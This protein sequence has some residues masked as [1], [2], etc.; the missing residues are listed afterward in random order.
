MSK[1]KIVAAA[2]L[3]T[4]LTAGRAEAFCLFSCDPTADNARSVF[5]NRL[6]QKFDPDVKVVKFEVSRFWQLDVEG[7]GH[8]AVEFYFTGTAEFPKGANLDCKPDEA[9]AVKEGCSASK[10]YSTTVSNQEIKGRQYIEPGATIEFKD[11]TRFDQAPSGWK[12][13]DGKAY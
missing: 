1:S 12:G 7:A 11:E 2:L 13:Q 4:A 10:Y 9:G 3:A 5:E 6:K 8:K